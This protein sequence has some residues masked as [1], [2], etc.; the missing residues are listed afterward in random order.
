MISVSDK[1]VR[2]SF[3]ALTNF[4]D[5]P[6]IYDGMPIC[7]QVVSRRRMDEFCCAATGVIEKALKEYK[8]QSKQ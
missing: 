7:L 2:K 3:E 4:L 5:D 6:E 8:D 1:I